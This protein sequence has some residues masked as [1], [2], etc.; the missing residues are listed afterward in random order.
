MA[1]ECATG[2]DVSCSGDVYSFGIVL[3]EILSRKR[4][5]D[6]IFT[7]G[8]NIVKFVET[9]FPDRILQVVDPEVLNYHHDCSVSQE[10]SIS[11]IERAMEE[12]LYSL[13]RIGLHC[14]KSS[15]SERMD[16]R[17]VAANLHKLKD[18]Y[19]EKI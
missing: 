12:C 8:L 13:L 11:T 5:T 7:D 10:V 1:P 17:D 16:M 9:N 18:A 2:G 4:P 19:L 6:D 3:L 15:P 14:T